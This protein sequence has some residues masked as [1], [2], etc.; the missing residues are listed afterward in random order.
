MTNPKTIKEL[1]KEVKKI[2]KKVHGLKTKIQKIE[3]EGCLSDL[4][5]SER[6]RKIKAI[7]REISYLN[8]ENISISQSITDLEGK[9]WIKKRGFNQP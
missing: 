9:K 2:E 8:N 5:L 1:K 6:D 7:N 3:S 4:Q